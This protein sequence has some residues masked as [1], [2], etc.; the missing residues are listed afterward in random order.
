MLK[1]WNSITTKPFI[2]VNIINVNFEKSKLFGGTKTWKA[3]LICIGSLYKIFRNVNIV[4]ENI[5]KV[6]FKMLI[7]IAVFISS[8][9]TEWYVLNDQ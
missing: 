3:F 2:N 8:S 5:L 4:N 1:F 7:V 9:I 6:H